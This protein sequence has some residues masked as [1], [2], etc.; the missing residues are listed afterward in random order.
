MPLAIKS[1]NGYEGIP[2]KILLFMQR[3]QR[4]LDLAP[5]I[6]RYNLLP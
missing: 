1:T 6:P 5:H 4:A 3:A 2:D